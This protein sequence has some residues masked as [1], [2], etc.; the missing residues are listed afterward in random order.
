VCGRVGEGGAYVLCNRCGRKEKKKKKTFFVDVVVPVISVVGWS[1]FA[2]L[3][4]DRNP[5]YSI[6]CHH[7]INATPT[8]VN[9]LNKFNISEKKFH[10]LQPAVAS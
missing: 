8:C 2:N 3:D 5:C 7:P 1:C 4:P 6:D 10:A 9:P